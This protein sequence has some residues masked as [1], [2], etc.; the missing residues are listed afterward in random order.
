MH[1]KHAK[2]LNNPTLKIKA[3]QLMLC[4]HL[5]FTILILTFQ[6]FMKHPVDVCTRIKNWKWQCTKNK[7][8]GYQQTKQENDII[9][10]TYIT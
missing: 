6:T 2:V 9:S 3:K 4:T 1:V 5:T 7:M 8:T 10:Q